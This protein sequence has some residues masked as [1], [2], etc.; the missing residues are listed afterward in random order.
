MCRLSICVIL[1]AIACPA[2][3]IAQDAAILDQKAGVVT[4]EQIAAWVRELDSAKFSVRKNAD[5]SLEAAQSAAVEPLKQ[6]AISGSPEVASRA[7]DILGRI[8][9]SGDV[10]VEQTAV[11]ALDELVDA[12]KAKA[13]NQATAALDSFRHLRQNDAIEK[14]R[15]M[16]AQVNVIHGQAGIESVQVAID[17]QWKGGDD[18]L[19]L[20]KRLPD[21]EGISLRRVELTDAA[22]VHLRSLKGLKNIQIYGT[23]ITDA[24][25]EAL[26]A[27]LPDANIERRN[28]ALLGIGGPILGTTGCSISTVLED[29]AAAEADIRVGDVVVQ[30]EGTKIETFQALQ[31]LISKRKPGE[32]LVM[33]IFRDEK[34]VT[35]QVT[36]GKWK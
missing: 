6:A 8:A 10:E 34:L 2:V 29:S 5:K 27:A 14:L 1:T 18:G 25:E 24:G 22:I 28:G 32:T 13:L 35:K 31:E 17:I 21:I 16:G 33:E 15:E 19:A 23:E 7:V 4:G 12:R 11:A 20:L 3:L 30:V 26:A 9:I 36:L